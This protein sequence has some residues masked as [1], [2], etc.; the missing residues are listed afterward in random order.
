MGHAWHGPSPVHGAPLAHGGSLAQGAPG[1]RGVPKHGGSPAWGSL[2]QGTMG[3]QWEGGSWG[4]PRTSTWR[5]GMLSRQARMEPS[6]Q[7]SSCLISSVRPSADPAAAASAPLL[8]TF[9]MVAMTGGRGGSAPCGASPGNSGGVPPPPLTSEAA[10]LVPRQP[11]GQCQPNAGGAAG[12]QH[13]LGSHG[14]AAAPLPGP[15]PLIAAGLA[16]APPKSGPLI[17]PC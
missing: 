12:D 13:R 8:P 2:A 15:L 17:P 3:T 10:L 9:L 5:P 7:T 6:S 11:D 1:A 16:P 14:T 4:S